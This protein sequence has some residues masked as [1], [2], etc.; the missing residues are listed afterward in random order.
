MTDVWRDAPGVLIS[1]VFA[2]LFMGKEI[3]G[4]G[5][6]WKRSG[7]MLAHGQALAW[8]QYVVALLLVVD[9][10]APVRWERGR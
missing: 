4:L 7:P 5:T 10:V 8:G 1:V 2:G 9:S 3:P 6:I